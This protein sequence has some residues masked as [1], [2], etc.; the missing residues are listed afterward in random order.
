MLKTAT[1]NENLNKDFDH[2]EETGSAFCPSEN[3]VYTVRIWGKLLGPNEILVNALSSTEK[4]SKA[5]RSSENI[6]KRFDAR[7]NLGDV[8]SLK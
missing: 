1:T 8:L 7:D 5:F 2:S 3:H 4:P 6:G